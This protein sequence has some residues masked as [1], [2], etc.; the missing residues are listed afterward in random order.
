MGLFI[1]NKGKKEK[2]LFRIQLYVTGFDD[3]L[4]LEMDFVPRKG[5]IFVYEKLKMEVTDV[6]FWLKEQNI[7]IYAEEVK[8]IT[9]KERLEHD[10]N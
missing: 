4:T 2:A 1:K 5:D 3:N 9:Y 10:N 6:E 8:P 7:K